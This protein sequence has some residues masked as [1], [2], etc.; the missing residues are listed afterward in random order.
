MQYLLFWHRISPLLRRKSLRR[1]ISTIK[2]NAIFFHSHI[3]LAI[4]PRYPE[5]HLKIDN[6]KKGIAVLLIVMVFAMLGVSCAHK[7]CP[8]SRGSVSEN[9]VN[10]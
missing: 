5:N 3:P 7:T 4:I 10:E 6:M 2:K 1:Q 9:I 8:A